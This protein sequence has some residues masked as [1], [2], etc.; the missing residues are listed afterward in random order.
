M[1][2]SYLGIDIGNDMLKLAFVK[3]GN[4]RKAVSAPMPVNLL[5]EGRITSMD[6]LGELIEGTLKENRMHAARAAAIIPGDVCYLRTTQMPRMS[7]DQLTYNIPYEFSDYLTGEV[8]D[9]LFDYALIPA[10][11]EKAPAEEKTP[12]EGEAVEEAGGDKLQLLIS[13]VDAG[14]VNELRQAVRE[15]GMKLAKAAPAE[16]AYIALIRDY[17]SRSGEKD[18]EYCFVDLGY[19]AI[20]MYMFHG[21]RHVATRALDVGLSSLTDIIAEAKGVDAHLAHT[22]LLTNFED[23]QTQDYCRAAYDNFS[24]ELMRALNFYR[25]SNPDSQITKCWLC[26]G[27]AGILPLREILSES[28]DVEIRTADELLRD[29]SQLTDGFAY[30]QAIGIAM[31]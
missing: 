9:Y 19:R 16:C 2:K 22:Y 18:G 4:V 1:A 5:R 23:C 6:A 21:P 29:A 17:E 13:A 25:F 8:K 30:I 15:G 31:E 7:A 3:D 26:G 14:V 20:R 12:A 11:E 27:G 10:E 24:V 28:L